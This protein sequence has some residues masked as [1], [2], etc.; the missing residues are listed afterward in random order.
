MAIPFVLCGDGREGNT[1]T[2]GQLVHAVSIALNV[3]AETVVQH[4]RNLVVAGLRTKGGRGSSAAKVTHLDAARLVAAILGSTKVLDSVDTVRECEQT[5]SAGSDADGLP[6]FSPSMLP[7]EHNF[8]EA[9]AA[10][11]ADADTRL[12]FEDFDE[13][14]R[15]FVGLSIELS[16]P[17]LGGLITFSPESLKEP[18][19][20]TPIARALN[21]FVSSRP[22]PKGIAYASP[23]INEHILAVAA[24]PYHDRILLSSGGL[25]QDRKIHG[26]SIMLLGRAFQEDGLKF[27]SRDE[28]LADWSQAG[29]GKTK[30]QRAQK[31]GGSKR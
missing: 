18:P 7:K 14:A 9:L 4:D 12:M 21:R 25:H 22:D 16:L 3:P 11:I 29:A 20:L 15:R 26:N 23:S 13:Y 27:T 24:R 30:K 10:I 6:F 19:P 31:E 5:T 17:R 2:P 28:A 1:L 8:V